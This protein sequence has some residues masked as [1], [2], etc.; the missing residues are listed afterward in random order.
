MITMIVLV[1]SVV[2]GMAVY[3]RT[4]KDRDSVVSEQESSEALEIADSLI[5][6]FS[7]VS[8]DDLLTSVGMEEY[9]E[10]NNRGDLND[11]LV[12][13]DVSSVSAD[14]L[15]NAC[16]GTGAEFN[17]KVEPSIGE[18]IEVRD[19][20]VLS[21]VV[22]NN[23]VDSNCGLSLDFEPRGT[24]SV[25]LVVHK[26]YGKDHP[27]TEYKDYDPADILAYCVH[28]GGSCDNTRVV[29]SDSWVSLPSSLGLDIQLDDEVDGYSLDEVRLL[30][31]GG[32]LGI[33]SALSAPECAGNFDLTMAK[34]TVEVN[35]NDVSRG[36]E[37][38]IPRENSMSYSSIFDYALYN[39][40]GLLQPN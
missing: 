37:V 14:F 38:F 27:N 31:V 15:E 25:G 19:D 6:V 4:L 36:K 34:V 32:V 18:Y 17:I 8:G 30:V 22:G 5:D 13:W 35:C 7:D 39:D 24:N 12:E 26:I 3:S 28:S 33:K 10:I 2:V 11:Y 21:F 20:M 29:T 23:S 40:N 1:V 9:I 16:S